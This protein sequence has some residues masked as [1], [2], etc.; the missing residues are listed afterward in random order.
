MT[1]VATKKKKRP[2]NKISIEEIVKIIKNMDD[3]ELETLEL[4]LSG[5]GDEILKRADDIKNNKVELLNTD[6][7]FK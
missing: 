4:M 7:L 1:T 5:E 3:A 6:D 2:Q